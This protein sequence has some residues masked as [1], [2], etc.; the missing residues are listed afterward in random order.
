M[1]ARTGDAGVLCRDCYEGWQTV[2]V[3]A[4]AASAAYGPVYTTQDYELFDRESER[5]TF[6]TLT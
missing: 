3:R 1:H 2:D 5:D 6:S 4:P